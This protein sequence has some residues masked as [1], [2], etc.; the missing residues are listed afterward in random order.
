MAFK[1]A[2]ALYSAGLSLFSRIHYQSAAR[3]YMQ[4][5]P[6]QTEH[7]A[8][9]LAIQSPFWPVS[10]QQ[11]AQDRFFLK[12]VL[13][14][15]LICW[16]TGQLRRWLLQAIAWGVLVLGILMGS[17]WVER[18]FLAR[19]VTPTYEESKNQQHYLQPA[20]DYFGGRYHVLHWTEFGKAGIL[21]HNRVDFPDLRI[22]LK[23]F[24]MGEPWPTRPVSWAI[25]TETQG[26]ITVKFPPGAITDIALFMTDGDSNWRMGVIQL[27]EYH[28]PVSALY[29]GRWYALALT[30]AQ[31]AAGEVD[32][33]LY[34]L[35]GTNLAVS[36]LVVFKV[37]AQ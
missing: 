17:A 18:D 2:E 6:E 26:T 3:A 13:H 30:D 8:R 19:Y 23:N 33:Q 11:F 37:D 27:D 16:P 14:Q 22:E 10:P 25:W 32:I 1:T 9:L 29:D 5:H 20:P 21:M 24:S 7:I 28:V 15:P 4:E 31:V 36:A 34:H 12:Q 35:S